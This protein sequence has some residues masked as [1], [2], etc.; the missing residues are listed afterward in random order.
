[1]RNETKVFLVLVP[2]F[3]IV[4]TIYALWTD[5]SEWVG[6]VALYLT[7]IMVGFVAWFFWLSGKTVDARPEDD[8]EGE[9]SDQSGD[10]GHF[11]PYSWWPLW[12][13]LS[14]TTAVLGVG[15]GWWLFVIAV[16]FVAISTIGW[17]FEYF[18]GERAV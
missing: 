16:P 12:L 4:A 6:I 5:W 8:L 11:A 9:I 7:S 1:M 2:F 10:Y 3:L 18:R 15:V 13:G 14:L 17:T